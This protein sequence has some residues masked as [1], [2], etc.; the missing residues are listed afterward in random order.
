MQITAGTRDNDPPPLGRGVGPRQGIVA[1][2]HPHGG[3]SLAC[4]RERAGSVMAR[5]SGWILRGVVIA[6]AARTGSVLA[7][8]PAFA[9]AP[10]FEITSF[11]NTV[12]G[13]HDEP[14]TINVKSPQNL[15]VTVT[16]TVTGPAASAGVRLK[17][18]SCN[19]LTTCSFT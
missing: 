18:D 9:D 7:A 2:A 13:S 10:T 19:N 15:S 12:D 11:N 3:V 5:G 6:L 16:M 8:S 17:S 14:L 1:T 4:T